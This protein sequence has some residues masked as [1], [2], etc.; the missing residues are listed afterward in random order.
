[1]LLER[2][3]VLV[4]GGA[5]SGLASTPRYKWT[6]KEALEWS[7]GKLVGTNT[8]THASSPV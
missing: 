1:M 6:C 5:R 4:F 2:E 3:D 7:E 8:V